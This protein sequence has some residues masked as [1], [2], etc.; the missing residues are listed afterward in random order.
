MCVLGGG[1]VTNDWCI[2]IGESLSEVPGDYKALEN[3][4]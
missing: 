2:T 3:N 1:M 4:I